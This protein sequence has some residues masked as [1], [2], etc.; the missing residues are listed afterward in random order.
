MDELS[1]SLDS[2]STEMIE[3]WEVK[4]EEGGPF[5]IIVTLLLLDPNVILLYC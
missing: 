4:K 3:R 5:P 1:I 2:E